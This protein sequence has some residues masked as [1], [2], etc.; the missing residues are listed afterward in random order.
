MHLAAVHVVGHGAE[1]GAARAE[2]AEA[3]LVQ[4]LQHVGEAQHALLLLRLGAELPVPRLDALL[5][6]GERPIHLQR[7]VVRS[8]AV[9]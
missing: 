7:D 1:A 5:L 6:H 4:R 3:A 8:G 2:A 9:L